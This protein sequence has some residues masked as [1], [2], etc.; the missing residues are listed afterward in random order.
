L[1]P[2]LNPT[3]GRAEEGRR[4]GRWASRS[5]PL[6]ER[7]EGSCSHR[8]RRCQFARKLRATRA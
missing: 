5:S 3:A 8:S 7:R 4:A 6:S 2:D 1:A